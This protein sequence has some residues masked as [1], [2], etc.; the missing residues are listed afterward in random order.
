MKRVDSLKL[1]PKAKAIWQAVIQALMSAADDDGLSAD[2]IA[3]EAGQ[4]M[5]NHGSGVQ[6][7]E[8]M[9]VLTQ[10]AD[11]GLLSQGCY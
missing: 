7:S 8:V 10:M 3:E 6:A 2:A 4:Y 1:A 9:R 5:A 11:V